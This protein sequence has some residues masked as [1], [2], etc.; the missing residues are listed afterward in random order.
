MYTD[1]DDVVGDGEKNDGVANVNGYG[2]KD[3]EVHMLIEMV[4]VIRMELLMVI[5]MKIRRIVLI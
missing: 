1:G 2:D 5:G 4:M 3:D